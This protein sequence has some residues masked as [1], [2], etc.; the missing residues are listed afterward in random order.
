M[1]VFPCALGLDS[2]LEALHLQKDWNSTEWSRLQVMK[3]NRSLCSNKSLPPL[4]VLTLG[5][6]L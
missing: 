4:P 3:N 1:F 6:S 5:F 2:I